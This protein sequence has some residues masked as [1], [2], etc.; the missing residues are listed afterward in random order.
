MSST[1]FVF[2]RRIGKDS[3]RCPTCDGCGSVACP[4][5]CDEKGYSECH[6]CEPGGHKEEGVPCEEC[7]GKGIVPHDP[8]Y[9]TCDGCGK[10]NMYCKC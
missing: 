9:D 5:T 10:W 4:L 1:T 6:K 3:M 2:N 8:N 7:K